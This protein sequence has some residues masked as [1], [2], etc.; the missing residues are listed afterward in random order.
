MRL[1][2]LPSSGSRAA[3]AVVLL[4]VLGAGCRAG[5]CAAAALGDVVGATGDAHCDRRYVPDDREPGSFCQEIVD[6]LAASNFEDDC[7]E[8]HAAQAD[9][10]RCPREKVLGGCKISKVND[11]GSEV[12]DWYYDVSQDTRDGGL[13]FVDPAKT[14]ADVQKL[15][16]DPSRYEEGA[17]YVDP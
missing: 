15:C 16:A 5:G 1:L 11:D 6:T 13:P 17:T 8:K 10:G 14:K 7:R 2:P 3:L 12:Y 9:D 4:G